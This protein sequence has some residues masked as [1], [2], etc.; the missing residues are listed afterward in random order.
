VKDCIRIISDSQ[1]PEIRNREII[2][3]DECTNKKN[4]LKKKEG[5]IFDWH[6]DGT[7]NFN[8]LTQDK[9]TEGIQNVFATCGL[10]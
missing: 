4:D 6:I 2:V 1:R 10:Q 8:H 3:M 9:I 7:K 5:K